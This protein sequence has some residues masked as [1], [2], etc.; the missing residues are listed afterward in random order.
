MAAKYAAKKDMSSEA[1]EAI[2]SMLVSL[3]EPVCNEIIQLL[4]DGGISTASQWTSLVEV[5]KHMSK[6]KG[7]PDPTLLDMPKKKS[8]PEPA[9]PDAPKKPTAPKKADEEELRCQAT[10][11]SGAPCTHKAKPGER[12]CGVH[13]TAK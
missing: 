8:S 9:A 1:T 11:K 5:V 4:H 13:A 6:K 7:S 12:Y 2:I 10:L 3:K